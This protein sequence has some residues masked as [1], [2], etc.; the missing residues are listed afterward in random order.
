MAESEPT[1]G[2]PRAVL[3]ALAASFIAFGV[4][5]LLAP[6]K[7]AAYADLSTTS[8]LGLVELRAF[9]GGVQIGLGVFLA[10]A[11]MRREW[12]LPGLVCAL[13]SLLGVFGARIYALTAEGWPGA[14]VLVFLAIE[15][16]G[17]VAAGFG[18][19]KIKQSPGEPGADE[20][21]ALSKAEKTLLMERTQPL[22][23][24]VPLDLSKRGKG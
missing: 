21:A 6:Q 20:V 2:T 11:A 15:L 14:M 8:R 9:Y 19:M 4:A 12:Q 17:V 1:S 16:A 24:T 18:L 23:R 7:L 3:L 5:F 13:L 10:V 22:E